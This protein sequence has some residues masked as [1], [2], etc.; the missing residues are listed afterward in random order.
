MSRTAERIGRQGANHTV[1]FTHQWALKIAYHIAC[2]IFLPL[3]ATRIFEIRSSSC[4]QN[5]GERITLLQVSTAQKAIIFYVVL[6]YLN[7][8]SYFVMKA[9]K[10]RLKSTSKPNK[11][12]KVRVQN[13]NEL[14]WGRQWC[15]P[16]PWTRKASTLSFSCYTSETVS[17]MKFQWAL[18]G[19]KFEKD[20][21][22]SLKSSKFQRFCFDIR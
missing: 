14:I 19:K 4:L 9:L 7:F 8:F 20:L 6:L 3:L 18:H 15:T 1:W 11:I 13:K 5:G 16:H 10:R 21:L 2:I 22:V 12:I 17:F